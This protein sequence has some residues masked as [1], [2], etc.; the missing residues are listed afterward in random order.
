MK[1][2]LLVLLIA[3]CSKAPTA[4]VPLPKQDPAQLEEWNGILRGMRMDLIDASGAVVK[5]RVSVHDALS[6]SK[7]SIVAF[8]ATYCP[9]CLEEMD[10]FDDLADDGH[11]VIGVSLDSENFTDVAKVL[12][13]KSPSYPQGVL[14]T[15]S[16]KRVGRSLETGVPFTM[17]LNRRG[18]V[19]YLFFGKATK[20]ELLTALERLRS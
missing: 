15:W 11:Q 6:A 7:P 18:E 13:E 8:W 12:T 20:D 10:M 17:V 16:M 1:L 4:S 14:Q 9:P 19:R 2:H 5:E 3:G